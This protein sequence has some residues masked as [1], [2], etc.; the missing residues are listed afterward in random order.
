MLQSPWRRSRVRL[1]KFVDPASPEYVCLC[2]WQR[3]ERKRKKIT[4]RTGVLNC[5]DIQPY[6]LDC[7]TIA[8]M[9]SSKYS[10]HDKDGKIAFCPVHMC[11]VSEEQLEMT[12]HVN[13]AATG[14]PSN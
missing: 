12:M 1:E 14:S 9:A 13:M 4:W 5:A 7:K 6:G 10:S 11:W 3:A 2:A 8:K